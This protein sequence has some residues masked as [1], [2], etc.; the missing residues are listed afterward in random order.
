LG[1]ADQQESGSSEGSRSEM[2]PSRWARMVEPKP[3]TMVEM[4]LG[5]A[6]GSGGWARSAEEWSG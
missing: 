6:S 5:C 4:A 3:A 2:R 1:K